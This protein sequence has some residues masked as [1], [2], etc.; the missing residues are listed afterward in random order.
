MTRQSPALVLS[1]RHSRIIWWAFVCQAL[2]DAADYHL[3]ALA[4]PERRVQPASPGRL[5][6][7][8]ARVQAASQAALA[9][10]A[11][12][13]PLAKPAARVP[14][15]TLVRTLLKPTLDVY[16]PSLGLA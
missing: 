11:R 5:G 15:A 14:Q 12:L 10:P 2:A 1:M 4:S 6:R 16:W 9:Q 13:E 7:P 8:V 3:Q